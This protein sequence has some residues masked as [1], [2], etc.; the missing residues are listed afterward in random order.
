MKMREE[1]FTFNTMD[2]KSK[3]CNIADLSKHMRKNKGLGLWS[4]MPLSTIFQLYRCGQFY[5]VPRENHRPVTDK[6][7]RI[8]L[9]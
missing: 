5:R 3:H 7:Y 6:L 4:L 8:M 9:Y 2:A 1:N